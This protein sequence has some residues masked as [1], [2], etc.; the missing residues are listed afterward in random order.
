MVAA[1]RG[2]LDRAITRTRPDL[3]RQDVT[4]RERELAQA[5]ELPADDVREAMTAS[6]SA[7]SFVRMV[8]TLERIR[9]SL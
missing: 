2:A 6:P 5:A 7:S 4:A 8:R 9:R 3:A 1:A